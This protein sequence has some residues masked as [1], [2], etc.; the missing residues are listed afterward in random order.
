MSS[1]G[2]PKA[3]LFSSAVIAFLLFLQIACAGFK[4]KQYQDFNTPTP[5]RGG[6]TLILGFL[7]GFERWDDEARGVRK[8]AIKIE[9]MKLPNVHIETLENRKRELAIRFI[10]KTFDRDQDGF[11]SDWERDSV[12]LILYGHS[13]GGA[14]VVEI[15]QEL[16][17]M[18]IPILLTI[19]IDSVGLVY[20]D[21]IIPSN[22][23]HAG[24]LFQNDGW[25]LQGEDEIEPENPDKTKIIANIRFDYRDKKVD[26]SSLSWERRIFSI[27]HVKMDADPEVWATVEQMILSEIVDNTDQILARDK[28]LAFPPAPSG[29]VNPHQKEHRNAQCLVASHDAPSEDCKA[30]GS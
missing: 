14:A 19:Q 16:K 3:K 6:Q 8:L 18:D 28:S 17:K 23:K 22:V 13:L 15:S 5:L 27:P 29:K 25:I 30:R 24:N 20:D 21:H 2:I 1:E 9:A 26:M 11:L 7:G 12:R 4:G 10:Q